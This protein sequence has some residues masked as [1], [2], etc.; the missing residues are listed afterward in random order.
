MKIQKLELNE[1][2]EKVLLENND[3]I[4]GEVDLKTDSTDKIADAIQA[5]VEQDSS[6]GETLTDASAKE[7][8]TEMQQT[9]KEV[10]A[11][12]GEIMLSQEDYNA[13]D[14]KNRITD[15]LDK[16]YSIA[17]KA[18]ARGKE[19]GA[20]LLIEGLPGSGKTAIVKN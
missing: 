12:V 5:S 7:I 19:V 6:T 15:A 2:L 20:N 18:M 17:K 4:L 10:D 13:I 14:A 11:G 16:S 9:A 8:A 3:E 1:N